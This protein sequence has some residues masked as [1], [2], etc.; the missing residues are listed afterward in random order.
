MAFL[1]YFLE[2]L[3]YP[4]NTPSTYRLHKDNLETTYFQKDVFPKDRTPAYGI[5]EDGIAQDGFPQTGTPKDGT[6]MFLGNLK[7]AKK[8]INRKSY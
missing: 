3:R 6:T 2:F 5:P 4:R 7:D 8:S 1:G